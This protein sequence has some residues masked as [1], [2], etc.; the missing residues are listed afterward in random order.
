LQA[1]IGQRPG[2]RPVPEVAEEFLPIIHLVFA[3]LKAWING[4][5]HRVSAKHLEAYLN[6]VTVRFEWRVYP[7]SAF[8][9]LLGIAG[10]A[11]APIFGGLYSGEWVHPIFSWSG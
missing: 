1:A 10:A 9:S 5:H 11:A 6:E 8:R 2:T 3:N 4:A 7:F